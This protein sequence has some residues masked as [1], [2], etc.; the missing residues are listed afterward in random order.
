MKVLL[1]TNIIIYREA[2]TIDLL[3]KSWFKID[4]I[5]QSSDQIHS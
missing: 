2:N 3:R 1:D 4:S 5:D